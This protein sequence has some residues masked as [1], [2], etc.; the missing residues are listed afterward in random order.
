MILWIYND[1]DNYSRLWIIDD[2]YIHIFIDEYSYHGNTPNNV[3]I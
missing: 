2:L 3:L 1:I